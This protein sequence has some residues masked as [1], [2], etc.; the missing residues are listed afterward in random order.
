MPGDHDNTPEAHIVRIKCFRNELCHSISTGIP[1]DVFEGTE[2]VLISRS[3][4]ALGL[5]QKEVDRLKTESIDHD[6]K[7][8]VEEA[9]RC[10]DWEPRVSNVEQELQELRGQISNLNIRESSTCELSSRLPDEVAEAFGRSQE[11]QKATEA[12]RSG[13]FAVVVITGAPGFGKTTVA[14]K[15][16]AG[17]RTRKSSGR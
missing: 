5:D 3:L 7:C 4:V 16:T 12:I 6:T 2:W 14:N 13:S 8:R 10:V 15:V 11:I 9:M 17:S 1:N